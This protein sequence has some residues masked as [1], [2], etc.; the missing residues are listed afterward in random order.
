MANLTKIKNMAKIRQ[1][2]Q[3]NANEMAKGP[4]ERGESYE[5]CQ[6]GKNS[7]KCYFKSNGMAKR[8]W[9]KAILTKMA[10]LEQNSLKRFFA[11]FGI[12]CIFGHK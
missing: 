6:Y 11:R 12:A 8:P 3:K 2:Q 1:S 4:F 10:N 7:P 5:N 9:K